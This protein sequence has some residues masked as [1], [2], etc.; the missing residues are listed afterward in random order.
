M[1]SVVT[2]G[3]AILSIVTFG[4]PEGVLGML[5]LTMALGSGVAGT[6]ASGTQL[7]LSYAGVTSQEDDR[8]LMGAIGIGTGIS[9]GPGPLIG[10]AIGAGA[11][12]QTE[13]LNRGIAVG[14]LF[15]MI[16][17]FQGSTDEFLDAPHKAKASVKLGVDIIGIAKDPVSDAVKDTLI[18]TGHGH[19]Q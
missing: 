10:G 13:G 19:D 5:T 4:V 1:T 14:G 15:Q 8:Q 2:L 11:G 9:S 16:T 7:G 17:D 12:G 3:L 18:G 6:V